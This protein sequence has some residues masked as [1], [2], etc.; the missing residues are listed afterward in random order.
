MLDITNDL[1]FLQNYYVNNIQFSYI[2]KSPIHGYGLF[3]KS[4]II[5]E[6]I[7]GFLGGQVIDWDHYKKIVNKIKNSLGEY[8]KYICMEWN[9]LDEDTLLIRPFRTRYSLINHSRT[10]NLKILRNPMRIIAT[11]DIEKDEELFLDYRDEPLRK[12]YLT[13]HGKNYL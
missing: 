3:A 11:R 8:Q 7:L 9:A 5:K 1:T 12:E 13:G 4:T 10:P 2:K 6:S